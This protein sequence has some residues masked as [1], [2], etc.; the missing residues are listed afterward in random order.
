MSLEMEFCRI[1]GDWITGALFIPPKS[2]HLAPDKW[3]LEDKF[4]LVKRSLLRG[5]VDFRGCDMCHLCEKV[6]SERDPWCA[7]YDQ[8]LRFWDFQTRTFSGFEGTFVSDLFLVTKTLIFQFPLY[9]I[10]KS[11]N[12]K[13]FRIQLMIVAGFQ[14]GVSRSSRS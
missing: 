13:W 6:T 11:S 9:Y 10:Y 1:S 4:F 12:W 14:G 2:K 7:K 8:S 5:H 3:C